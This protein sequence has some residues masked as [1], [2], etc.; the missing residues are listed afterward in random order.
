V[1]F[2][3]SLLP[4]GLALNRLLVRDL[5]R[6]V[7]DDLGR[8]P[9]ILKDR[10][11]QRSEALG[12][13]AKELAGTDG[14]V[15]AMRNADWREA[16]RLIM[17]APGFAGEEPFLVTP[18]GTVLVGAG[19]PGPEMLAATRSADPVIAVV[20]AEGA[21]RTLA[22]AGVAAA[23]TWLGAAGV[24]AAVDEPLAGTLAGL[25]RADVVILG[26]DG[27][28]V[29]STLET[30][31][32]GSVGEGLTPPSDEAVTEV[33][34]DVGRFWA[35]SVPVGDVARVVFARSVDEE[36]ALLPRL[37]RTALLATGLA[38]LLAL[39]AGGLFARALARPVE[40]LAG[41]ADRVAAGD[42][43]VALES[44]SVLEVE[45]VSRAFDD[46][47][48]RLAARLRELE[49]ANDALEDRQRRLRALQAE[50]SQRDRLAAS[51]RLVAEL[52]H[53][54]RNPVANVRNCL[55]VIRRRVLD[56]PDAL[57]FAEMA[58]DELLRMHELAERVLDLHRPGT[59]VARCDPNEV[60][61]SIAQLYGAAGERPKWP[62][63]VAEGAP[64]EACISADALKQVLMNLIEN[65][66]EAMPQGGPIDIAVGRRN[67]VVTIDV[68][69][70]GSGVSE[71]VRSRIFDPFF[72]TK[73]AVTGVGL[74]LYVA[75]GVVA[76]Y[77]GR[78]VTEERPD[79]GALFRIEVP[80]VSDEDG[81]T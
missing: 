2:V 12:M 64:L 46:M 55:E 75:Q 42:F 7:R 32:P 37:R 17:E 74:G 44:S 80:R 14:L 6:R 67:G 59:E 27:R 76:R 56:D 29:A 10:D 19:A 31:P 5:E 78:L 16:E 15:D 52:A 34:T 54:I 66:R 72:T 30:V 18:E 3:V 24:T 81:S 43:E 36:L 65:A 47:R 38:L 70:R 11:A 57:E 22:L 79:G 71:E 28:V 25:T 60:A 1:A 40:G 49:E 58:I 62:V 73:D 63:R 13:H 69:D 39:L 45:R 20:D 9:M 4:A 33:V 53:E 35:V 26:R 61:R 48:A 23:G 50:L 68:A 41:A 8:A 77:G 51:S 21:P